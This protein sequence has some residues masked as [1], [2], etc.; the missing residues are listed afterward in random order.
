M[1]TIISILLLLI[2]FFAFYYTYKDE[3][4]HSGFNTGYIIHLRGYVAGLIFITIGLLRLFG[5]LK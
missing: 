4:N 2:G 1:K 5:Y 3:K